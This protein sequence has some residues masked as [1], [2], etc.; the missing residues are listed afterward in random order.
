MTRQIRKEVAFAVEVL[1]LEIAADLVAFATTLPGMDHTRAEDSVQEAF[2]AAALAWDDKLAGRSPEDRRR[3]LFSVVKNKTID[4][5]RKDRNLEQRS[6]PSEGSW[7]S[8][9]TAD[10]AISSATLA[11]CWD[12]IQGMPSVRGKVAF[13][14]WSEDWTTSEIA[15]WLE[16]S[17][18]TVR[19]HLKVARDELLLQLGADIPIIGDPEID[20]GGAP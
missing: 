2:H 12:A 16:I 3:W 1:Y 4:Q 15:T 20:G 10:C 18:A 14:R 6:N 11:R 8:D 13:L 17:Q 9:P 19:G 5:W 7:S